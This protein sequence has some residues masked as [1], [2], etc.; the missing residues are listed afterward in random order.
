MP[1]APWATWYEGAGGASV[2]E[3]PRMGFLWQ[4]PGC[5]QLGRPFCWG[6]GEEM[7]EKPHSPSA[8]GA[9][10]K[11]KR[12][13]SPTALPT[14]ALPGQQDHTEGHPGLI[15]HPHTAASS[16]TGAGT[17]TSCRPPC[18]PEG[19]QVVSAGPGS[20]VR[21]RNAFLRET[22]SALELFYMMGCTYF[23]T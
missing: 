12:S 19:P 7:A 15:A 5:T 13:R 23:H 16:D 6:G 22:D 10:G 11:H 20:P 8:P 9:A 3:L 21:P 18:R 2:F 4:G 14:P 17:W 1:T